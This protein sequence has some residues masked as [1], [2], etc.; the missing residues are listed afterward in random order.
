MVTRQSF[1]KGFGLFAVLIFVAAGCETLQNAGVPGLE[2]Y[3]RR[4]PEEAAHE[5]MCREKFLTERDH[6]ALY[7]LLAHRI[8]NGMRVRQVEDVLGEPG[9]HE[10]DTTRIQSDG[11]YHTTDLA[12]RWGPDRRGDSVMLFFRDGYLVNFNPDDY[13]IRDLKD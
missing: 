12:Y 6:D 10:P 2:R 9:E 5:R 7:W 11:L 3:V 13:R 4:S 1:A 8:G